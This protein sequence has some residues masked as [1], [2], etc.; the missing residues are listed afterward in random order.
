VAPP[1]PPGGEGAVAS[2]RPADEA[3]TP[4]LARI[5]PPPDPADAPPAAPAVE[6]LSA[7]P[8]LAAA[9][10][11]SLI[12][13]EVAPGALPRPRA[14]RRAART[15]CPGARSPHAAV[16]RTDTS[17]SAASLHL[18]I[19]PPKSDGSFGQYFDARFP[20]AR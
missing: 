6:A 7:P 14:A 5:P 20:F 1:L 4:P 17:P 10:A 8:P 15:S 3:A 16:I 13:D 19:A 12:A 2:L 18:R 11:C 9:G